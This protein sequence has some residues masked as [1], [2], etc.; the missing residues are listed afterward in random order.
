MITSALSLVF[1][2]QVVGEFGEAIKNDN[3]ETWTLEY[4]LVISPHVGRYYGC[5]RSREVVLRPGTNF[6]MQHRAALTKCAKVRKES[7]SEANTV[8]AQRARPGKFGP[9]QTKATFDT[10]ESIHIARGKDL[11]QQLAI[12]VQSRRPQPGVEDGS[13]RPEATTGTGPSEAAT[14]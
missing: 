10:I 9:D 14:S 13:A 6:E 11:D 1:G 12:R 8:L 2:L 3:P 7:L 5:L 4:P